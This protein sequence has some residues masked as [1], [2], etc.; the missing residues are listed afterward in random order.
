LY[1][2]TYVTLYT[3]DGTITLGG[4]YGAENESAKK[5]FT[6]P[7]SSG[8]VHCVKCTRYIRRCFYR[9]VVDG[10]VSTARSPLSLTR[11]HL[12]GALV[13]QE[14]YKK[15]R[16]FFVSSLNG[17]QKYADFRV[18]FP[19]TFRGE[20]RA[21]SFLLQLINAS[22][23]RAYFPGKN[24]VATTKIQFTRTGYARACCPPTRK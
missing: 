1:I 16:P 12:I 6:R 18:R 15:N 7:A 3:S 17:K 8:G 5:V 10:Y 20:T 2:Y 19:I 22:Y 13:S 24:Y 14:R 23:A 9:A 11:A 4:R 21:T